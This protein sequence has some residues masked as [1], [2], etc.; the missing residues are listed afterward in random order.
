[1]SWRIDQ[2]NQEILNLV[3]LGVSFSLGGSSSSFLFRR[4]LISTSFLLGLLLLLGFFL[5]LLAS[6]LSLL[7]SLSLGFSDG[8]THFQGVQHTGLHGGMERDGSSLDSDTTLLFIV[9]SVHNT[10]ITGLVHG[11]DTSSSNQRVRKGGLAVVDVGDDGNVSDVRGL[12]HELA[13]LI[14]GK[15][16]HFSLVLFRV[17]FRTSK[18]N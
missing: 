4:F 15:V 13:N 11:N 8:S 6:F 17:R 9:T 16:H 2:V 5:N 14:D 18:Q 3:V 7:G 12:V 1:V 10:L